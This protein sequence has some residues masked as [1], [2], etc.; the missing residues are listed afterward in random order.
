MQW[1]IDLII[2]EIGVPPCFIDRGDPAVVDYVVGDL[3]ID[4]DWHDLDLSA[5]VPENAKGVVIHTLLTTQQVGLNFNLRKKGNTNAINISQAWSAVAFESFSPDMTVPCDENR[6]IQYK[7]W[8][9]NW[10]ILQLT[11]KGWWL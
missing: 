4:N 9:G 11:V 7:V 1:L 3:V 2:E 5:I 10:L 8:P 6:K